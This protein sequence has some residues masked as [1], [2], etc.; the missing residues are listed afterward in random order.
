VG[1]GTKNDYAGED[2]QQ[3]TRVTDIPPV[4]GRIGLTCST[5][6]QMMMMMVKILSN[7]QLH[8]YWITPSDWPGFTL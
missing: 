4:W 3:F 2:Q 6:P 8:H 5:L 7:L 1:L